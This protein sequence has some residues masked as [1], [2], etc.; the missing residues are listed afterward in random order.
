[1]GYSIFETQIVY[2]FFNVKQVSETFRISKTSL[3]TRWKFERHS[4]SQVAG[5]NRR[6]S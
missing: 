3:F 2:L 1:M 6:I 5:Y 4:W